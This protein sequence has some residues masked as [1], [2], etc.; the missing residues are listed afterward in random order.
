MIP[1]GVIVSNSIAASSD[2]LQGEQY[3]R[4]LRMAPKSQDSGSVP[5]GGVQVNQGA[6]NVLGHA[7]EIAARIEHFVFADPD[8]TLEQLPSERIHALAL[9]VHHVVVL[10]E[11]FA[12]GEVLRF[13]LLLRALNCLAD[14]AGFNGHAFFHAQTFHQPGDAV[15]THEDAHEV[16]FEREVEP[17]RTRVALTPGAAAQLVVDTAGLMAF[18][19]DDV[20]TARRDDRLVVAVGLL[21]EGREDAL[22]VATRDPVEVLEVEKVHELLVVNAF[23]GPWAGVRPPARP[24]PAGAP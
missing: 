7:H 5:F 11:M 1:S 17:R 18:G 13:H 6:E 21:L 3:R 12:G 14:H 16:V 4:R 15:R 10:E 24:A 23:P 2:W 9:L 19:A 8:L 20:K 22:V